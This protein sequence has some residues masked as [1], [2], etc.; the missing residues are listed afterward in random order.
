MREQRRVTRFVGVLVRILIFVVWV[1]VTTSRRILLRGLRKLGLRS[2]HGI[3]E[4]TW[5]V[6]ER[7][8]A[9]EEE[10]QESEEDE[11]YSPSSQEEESDSESEEEEDETLERLRI[12]RQ[13]RLSRPQEQD[14]EEEEEENPLALISDLSQDSTTTPSDLAPYLIAHHLSQPS[15]SSAQPLTRTR[16]KSLLSLQQSNSTSPS[17]ETDSIDRNSLS[18]LSTA[19]TSHQSDLLS[20]TPT[21]IEN[22]RKRKGIPLTELEREKKRQEYRESLSSFCCVCTVEP[23][24]IILWPCRTSFPSFSLSSFRFGVSQF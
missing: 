22:G 24:T 13:L 5:G 11:E 23:R 15:S 19:I 4:D 16:F 7:V 1:L 8:D 6:R 2:D 21:E 12:A 17:Q 20:S 3:I 9:E 18:L 10:D 14:Q